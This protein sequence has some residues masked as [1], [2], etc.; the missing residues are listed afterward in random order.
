[1]FTA[2]RNRVIYVPASFFEKD[3]FATVKIDGKLPK[4]GEGDMTT[5]RVEFYP[6]HGPKITYAKFYFPLGKESEKKLTHTTID[7]WKN[8]N[9]TMKAT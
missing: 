6:E 4:A 8:L 7:V 2:D 3:F 5:Y 1:M 9:T